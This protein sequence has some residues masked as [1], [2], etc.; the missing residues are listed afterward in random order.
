MA[1]ED[2]IRPRD[3]SAPVIKQYVEACLQVAQEAG[4]LAIDAH[5]AIIEDASGESTEELR[6]YL[7]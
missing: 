3:H 2:M 1:P 7:T 6:P 5:S 4:V